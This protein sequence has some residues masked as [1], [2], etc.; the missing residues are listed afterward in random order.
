MARHAREFSYEKLR[1]LGPA[2]FLLVPVVVG[3]YLL[4]AFRTDF[5]GT[6]GPLSLQGNTDASQNEMFLDPDG[7]GLKNWEETLYG[8]NPSNVDTDQDGVSDRDEAIAGTADGPG[9]EIKGEQGHINL[10]ATL[11]DKFMDQGGVIALTKGRAGGDLLSSLLTNEVGALSEEGFLPRPIPTV[12]LETPDIKTS[13]DIS[14]AAVRA[15]LNAVAEIFSRNT[16]ELKKDNLTLLVEILESGAFGRLEELS[17]Y[18]TASETIVDELHTL[19]VPKS[20]SWYHERQL[21]LM[22]EMTRHIAIF[23]ATESDPLKTLATVEPNIQIKEELVILN[24]QDLYNWLS[25]HHI[26][27]KPEDSAYKI[28]Y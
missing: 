27:L 15:Y 19:T 7:D 2:L 22:G 5:D 26:A 17:P 10:T 23:Q 20:L 25:Q 6:K 28:I 18:L 16:K 12:S 14:N 9:E 8:T 24:R 11:F 13:D 1:H 21:F 4:F 3:V